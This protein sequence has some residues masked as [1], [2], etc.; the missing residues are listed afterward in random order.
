MRKW[1]HSRSDCWMKWQKTRFI[2]TKTEDRNTQ[3]HTAKAYTEGFV[4]RVLDRKTGRRM[5]IIRFLYWVMVR[6]I[7]LQRRRVLKAH[8]YKNETRKERKIYIRIFM[9]VWEGNCKKQNVCWLMIRMMMH[10]LNVHH[11]VAKNHLLI[12]TLKL[13]CS[14]FWLWYKD[15][16]WLSKRNCPKNV[17]FANESSV[18]L[19]RLHNNGW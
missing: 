14:V 7:G 13:F 16:S 6:V 19:E 18:H 12:I 9:L 3:N 5:I 4:D 8:F 15:T 1:E 11:H 10:L 17:Y 2:D